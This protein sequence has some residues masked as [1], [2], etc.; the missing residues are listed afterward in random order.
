MEYLA[1]P[2]AIYE[3]SF[4]TI[5]AEANLARFSE[6]ESNVATRIIH[7]CGMVEIAD[8][9]HFSQHAAQGGIAAL[10]NGCKIICDAKMVEMGLIRRN[11]PASC[12]ILTPLADERTP[13]L[14]KELQTTRSSAAMNLVADKIEG[15]IFVIGNA[16]TAL[17]ALL[18]QIDQGAPAPALIIGMPVGFVGA[19]ES[20][21]ELHKRAHLPSI[22]VRG[23]Q[24]GSAMA[25]AALNALAIMAAGEAT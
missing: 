23:R 15:A 14:A 5:A 22:L 18:E 13:D 17:F 8:K 2:Q 10:Q 24:G 3:L 25:A 1:N 4:A 9:L 16:P 6:D 19:A 20:K 7:A 12:T 21:E 11:I